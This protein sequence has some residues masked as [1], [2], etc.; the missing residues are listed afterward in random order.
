VDD[1]YKF[2]EENKYYAT[3]ILFNKR[4]L[5][6]KGVTFLYVLSKEKVKSFSVHNTAYIELKNKSYPYLK[7]DFDEFSVVNCHLSTQKDAK[8]S[9][10]KTLFGFGDDKTII[11]G[12]FNTYDRH[13]EEMLEYVIEQKYDDATNPDDCNKPITKTFKPFKY[14][15]EPKGAISHLD[16]IYYKKVNLSLINVLYQWM[17]MKQAIIS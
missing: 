15:S 14:D 10:L 17:T 8:F 1:I 16:H 5:S 13:W 11:V 6:A 12:D 2:A 7:V 4:K 9:A 3:G